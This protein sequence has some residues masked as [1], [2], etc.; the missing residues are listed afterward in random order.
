MVAGR[1]VSVVRSAE[2]AWSG[3]GGAASAV[4]VRGP[5]ETNTYRG[6][7]RRRVVEKCGMSVMEGSAVGLDLDKKYILV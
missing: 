5:C 2:R 7:V 6:A 4:R 1:A 3:G